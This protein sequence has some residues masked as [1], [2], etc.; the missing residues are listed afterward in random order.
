M[1]IMSLIGKAISKNPDQERIDIT[2][3]NSRMARKMR[4]KRKARRKMA[5]KSRKLNIKKGG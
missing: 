1:D 4:N 5:R 2:P 3:S